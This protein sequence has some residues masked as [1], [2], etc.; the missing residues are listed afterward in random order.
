MS[1]RELSL[2]LAALGEHR[3]EDEQADRDAGGE[4][5]QDLDDLGRAALPEERRSANCARHREGRHDEAARDR[6][7]LLEAERRPD[8]HREEKACG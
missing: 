4:P 2:S 3:A 5:L 8:Q 6:S 7:E 1:G